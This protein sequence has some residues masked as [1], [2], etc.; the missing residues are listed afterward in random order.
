MG[1]GDGSVFLGKQCPTGTTLFGHLLKNIKSL[2][3]NEK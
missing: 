2:K 3:D 1:N